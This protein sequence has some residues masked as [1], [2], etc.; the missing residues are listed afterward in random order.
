MQKTHG[1]GYGCLQRR[2]A[3]EAAGTLSG[4]FWAIIGGFGATAGFPGRY[5]FFYKRAD[6]DGR[7]IGRLWPGGIAGLAAPVLRVK[8]LTIP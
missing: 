2:L 5:Y 1:P 3:L 7:A 6:P 8:A 4:R